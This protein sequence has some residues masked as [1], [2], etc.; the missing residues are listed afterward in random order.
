MPKFIVKFCLILALGSPL[1]TYSQAIDEINQTLLIDSMLTRAN[2]GLADTSDLYFYIK[3]SY[4]FR[5]HNPTSS[6]ELN[7][8]YQ[9]IAEG[10]VDS[11]AIGD[12]RSCVGRIFKDIGLYELAIENYL[13]SAEIF[14]AEKNYPSL[15][16]V[17]INI[18]N[19]FYDLEMYEDASLYYQEVIGFSG[20]DEIK[21]A[22]S[23]CINNLGLIESNRENLDAALL[24]FNRALKLREELN[25]PSLVA[26][27]HVYIADIYARM[28]NHDSAIAHFNIA[29]SELNKVGARDKDYGERLWQV[30]NARANLEIIFEHYDEAHPYADSAFQ[31]AVMNQIPSDAVY[32]KVQDAH[33]YMMMGKLTQAR[34]EVQ[35]AHEKASE[36]NVLNLRVDAL[37][38]WIEIETK[39]NNIQKVAELQDELLTLNNQLYDQRKTI[40]V[41]T[42]IY[43]A[44]LDRM[45]EEART[46]RIQREESERQLENEGKLNEL[47]L[48][49]FITVLVFSITVTVMVVLINRKRQRNIE[50][51]QIIRQQKEEIEKANVRLKHS[52]ELLGESLKEKSTFMS[53]MSHEI[54]TPMN[55][56]G[57]LSELLL[58]DRLTPEQEQLVRNINHS[59]QRLT[60]LVDDILDYSRLEGGRVRLQP[61]NFKLQELINEVVSLNS[62]RAQSNGTVIHTRI[63]HDLPEYLNGDASRLAQV[64]NNLLSNSV[65]FTEGGHIYL[66]IFEDEV[67]LKKVR[68]GF[69]VEDTGI[70]ISEQNLVHIFD[71]FRQATGDIHSRYG[72]TGLGLAICKQLV[73]LLGGSISVKSTLG[74]GSTFSFSVPFDIG[75]AEET[76]E[77]DDSPIMEG[78]ELLL[79]EDDKMNQFVAQKM[80]GK[81]GLNITIA[82]NGEE[83]V[84]LCTTEKFDLILMDI[85]MPVMDG[86]EAAVHIRK[87]GVNLETPIIA[88]TADVQ[89]ETKSK[90]LAAGMND[91]LTKPFQRNILISTLTRFIKL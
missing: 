9:Q 61:R 25:S 38:K 54:R 28:N 11:T 20:G 90:A 74:K 73:D 2:S 49:L 10:I 6:L 66:R 80:L 78:K 24:H 15:S 87:T 29:R 68:I 62:K 32:S 19:V 75:V 35:F 37:K 56:I 81:T 40:E 30:Y 13:E 8:A 59:S 88:L 71:E 52:N 82:G 43:R 16:Y 1:S 47:L 46:S 48:I 70:G 39:T 51:N 91:V 50:D 76:V 23:V 34:E 18:G 65:K 85:Q 84:K 55:A 17:L 7:R 3:Y 53:K 45:R 77:S 67:A 41:A 5:R 33:I 86:I 42:R 69:E 60:A 22:Q 4:V 36:T 83:A 72:G 44:E 64:L 79:V 14:R 27:S 63:P 26:H 12:L 57:G 31:R 89:G 58:N 21:Q